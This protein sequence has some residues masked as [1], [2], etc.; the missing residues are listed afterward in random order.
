M[1]KIAS[2]TE[3]QLELRHI[4]AY[5]QRERPS[6]IEI[7][8][9]LYGLAERVASDV[10]KDVEALLD[11]A[12]P[13]LKQTHGS[14]IDF[15]D[16]DQMVDLWGFLHGLFV[17]WAQGSGPNYDAR[18]RAKLFKDAP[19]DEAKKW[20]KSVTDSR[21]TTLIRKALKRHWPEAAQAA[22]AHKLKK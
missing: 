2:P 20:I 14:Q 6:R 12:I 3:L 4:L 16:R 13:K 17:T 9:F 11:T 5:S 22:E 8:R 21:M 15:S 19:S 1:R 10:P 7:A 18:Q